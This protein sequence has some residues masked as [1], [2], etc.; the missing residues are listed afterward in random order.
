VPT[1]RKRAPRTHFS[2]PEIAQMLGVDRSAIWRKRKAGKIRT[3]EIMGRQL[4]S[5]AE[6]RRIGLLKD[7]T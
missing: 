1:P 2:I 7:S 3:E 4:V 6:M 5:V